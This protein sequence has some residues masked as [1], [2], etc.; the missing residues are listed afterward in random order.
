MLLEKNS[1]IIEYSL[2]TSTQKEHCTYSISFHTSVYIKT[3]WDTIKI[4]S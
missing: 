1:N 2:I 4:D 3:T